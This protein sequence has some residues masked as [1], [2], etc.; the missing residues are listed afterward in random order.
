MRLGLERAETGFKNF[1]SSEQEN[2]VLGFRKFFLEFGMPI[3]GLGSL[4]WV[5]WF[6]I[7]M[8][9]I[10]RATFILETGAYGGSRP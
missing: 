6:C 5:E 2:L 7:G 3:L 8:K 9:R 1:F 10:S 4:D